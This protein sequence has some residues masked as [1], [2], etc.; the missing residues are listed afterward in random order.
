[1]SFPPI[2]EIKLRVAD[3][4]RVVIHRNNYHYDFLLK[5][6]E[7]IHQNLLI[8]ESNGHYQFKDFLRDEKAMARLFEAFIRNF[9]RNETSLQVRS[10]QI[11]WQFDKV[12][13]EAQS[14]I[15]IMQTDISL[16]R[17]TQKLI[18]DAKYYKE[19]FVK[20]FDTEKFRTP[21][22]YQLF[23]YLIN[24]QTDTEMSQTCGGMLLY[25]ATYSTFK[26][27]MYYH[28]H[29]IGIQAI[30]LNQEWP[31]IKNNLLSLVSDL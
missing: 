8:D 5:I 14:M 28:K 9:Y 18:I 24:Q 11:K 6:C 27:E 21:N 31:L 13:P 26:H 15:P 7:I 19:A 25:P 17:K 30:N 12:S 4:Q 2:D 29:R 1:M 23:A 16:Y 20:R 10:E 3:F 22:L